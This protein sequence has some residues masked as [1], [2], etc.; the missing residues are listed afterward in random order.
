MDQSIGIHHID[1]QFSLS[2]VGLCYV[3]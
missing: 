1:K 2:G 3:G